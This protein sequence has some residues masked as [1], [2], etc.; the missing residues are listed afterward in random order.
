M[1]D[2]EFI[3]VF[4]Q[5]FP[6]VYAEY[7]SSIETNYAK[8]LTREVWHDIL[9]NNLNLKKTELLNEKLVIVAGHRSTAKS[10]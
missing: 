2:S 8:I 10:D 9:K 4:K 5:F 1:E 6:F 3:G 7:Y